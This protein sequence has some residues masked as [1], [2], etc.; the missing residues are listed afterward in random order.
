MAIKTK[1]IHLS[2][3]YGFIQIGQNKCGISFKNAPSGAVCKYKVRRQCLGLGAGLPMES[4]SLC[5]LSR[6]STTKL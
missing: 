2:E 3:V 5:L 6:I 1:K 4:A